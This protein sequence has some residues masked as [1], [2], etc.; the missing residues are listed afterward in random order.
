[1]DLWQLKPGHKV[2]TSSGVNAEVLSETEDG[3]WV[4][5]R[6]FE[7]DDP[8]V[9]GRED[10][11]HS[12][13]VEALLGIVLKPRWQGKAVVILHSVSENAESGGGYVAET[14]SGIPYGVMVSSGEQ[15]TAEQALNQI[16]AALHAFGFTG[17]V[18]VEDVTYIGHVQR[19]EVQVY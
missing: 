18:E 11:A 15:D 13:E 5:I 12:D 7:G 17:R 8:F 16:I 14:L 10:L 1:M 19:Y 4:R 3:E 6:Y 9:G 2:R